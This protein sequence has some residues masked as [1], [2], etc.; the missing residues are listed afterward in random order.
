MPKCHHVHKHPCDHTISCSYSRT[1]GASSY[2]A[3]AANYRR[4]TNRGTTHSSKRSIG[5]DGGFKTKVRN[6]VDAIPAG[7]RVIAHLSRIVDWKTHPDK[8]KY[9]FEHLPARVELLNMSGGETMV[10]GEGEVDALIKYLQRSRVYYINAGETEFQSGLLRERLYP[11]LVDT[12]VGFVFFDENKVPKHDLDGYF[13]YTKAGNVLITNRGKT[14]EWYYANHY[15]S[16]SSTSSIQVHNR[17]LANPLFRIS[18]W[19]DAKEHDTDFTKV[20]G[21]AFL[22]ATTAPRSTSR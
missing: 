17:P 10:W 12:Y 13:R 6:L 20:M 15:Y 7:G 3:T 9:M 22:E 19:Y 21:K 5:R 18:P 16:S 11:A 14:P 1:D 2:C 8:I 4:A